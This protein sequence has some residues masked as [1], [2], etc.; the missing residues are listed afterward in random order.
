VAALTPALPSP[1]PALDPHIWVNVAGIKKWM[2]SMKQIKKRLSSA[3]KYAFIIPSI[4]TSRAIA[5]PII[6]PFSAPLLVPN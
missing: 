5:V 1:A 4:A 6:R 3:R 2:L